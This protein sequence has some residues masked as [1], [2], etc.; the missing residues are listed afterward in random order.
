MS[1]IG[2][3]PISVPSDVQVSIEGRNVGVSGPKGSLDLDVPGE[4]EVRQEDDMILVERPNDD[5]KNKA[6]H[7]LTRSLV[8]N[9]VIGVSEGFKKELEIVGVGY[10][11]AEKGSNGLE[12]QLGF[13]HPVEVKAPEGITF[14]VPE[15]TR[16]IVSGINKEVVGQVAAD[17]R[18]YRKPEPYKGKGIRY[19]G[20]HVARKA[21]KAAK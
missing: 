4:I 5:R 19:A 15:P 16:I 7:G 8:N 11:A 1:R 20:E 18:S 12:L 9:M 17:I 14:E 21:G 6:L 10:R 13:S 3:E 2:K